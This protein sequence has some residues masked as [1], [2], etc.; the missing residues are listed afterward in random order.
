EMA[1]L[2][3]IPAKGLVKQQLG[4]RVGQMLL[5]AD[6]VGDFH[7]GVVDGDGQVVQGTP[8]DLTMT[9]S[10]MSLV[11]KRTSPRIKSRKTISRFSGTR[12]RMVRG[13]PSRSYRFRVSSSR[14]AHLPE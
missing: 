1:E 11:W 14:W 3:R 2:R 7:Q 5:P 6:D 4:G 10:P 8:L 9:K 13:R 12:K